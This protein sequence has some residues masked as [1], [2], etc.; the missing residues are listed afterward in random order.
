M[1]LT[2][3]SNL[4]VYEVWVHMDAIAYSCMCLACEL[5]VSAEPGLVPACGSSGTKAQVAGRPQA[6]EGMCAELAGM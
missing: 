1:C 4:C 5:K 3:G 2:C 6:G